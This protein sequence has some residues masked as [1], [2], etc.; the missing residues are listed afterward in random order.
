[1]E[2]A[3]KHMKKWADKK[4]RPLQFRARDQVLIKLRPEQIR[5]RGRK[6]QRLVQKYEGPVEV[7][8]KIRDTSYRVVY[9]HG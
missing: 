8:K 4:R 6:D 5:F 7:L 1:M 9:P 2:K 3:S